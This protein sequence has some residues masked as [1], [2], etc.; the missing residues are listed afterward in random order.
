MLIKWF[1]ITMKNKINM[2]SEFIR[3]FQQTIRTIIIALGMYNTTVIFDGV[4]TRII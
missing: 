2:D 1:K 3:L 4:L